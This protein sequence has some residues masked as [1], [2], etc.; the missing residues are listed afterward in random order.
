MQL[1]CE[2]FKMQSEDIS[3]QYVRVFMDQLIADSNR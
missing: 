3:R 1:K 2:Y